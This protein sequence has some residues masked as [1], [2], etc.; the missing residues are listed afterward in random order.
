MLTKE[1]KE[2]A[3]ECAREL[4]TKQEVYNNSP[5]DGYCFHGVYVWTDYDCACGWCE[6]GDYTEYTNVYEYGLDMARARFEREV[7]NNR[8]LNTLG[9]LAGEYVPDGEG[10][11][12]SL[13]DDEINAIVTVSRIF[14][15]TRT[16]Y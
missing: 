3:L 10:F 7:A 11:I 5:R 2:Y 13:S 1:L 12:R 8:W 4:R 15:E 16:K 14:R 6:Q 9:S